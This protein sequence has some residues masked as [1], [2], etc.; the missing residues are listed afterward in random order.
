[1]GQR[2]PVRICGQ[3]EGRE[4]DSDC[5]RVTVHQ[6]NDLGNRELRGGPRCPLKGRRPRGTPPSAGLPLQPFLLT[7][8]LRAGQ[9]CHGGGHPD[10]G[11][12]DWTPGGRGGKRRGGSSPEHRI[13]PSRRGSLLWGALGCRQAGPSP[14]GVEPCRPTASPARIRS[15]R[16]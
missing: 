7:H 15:H 3:Q 14:P 12:G 4:G 16:V 10:S 9:Q 11:A 13:Q 5:A 6:G 2:S 1:M 8:L